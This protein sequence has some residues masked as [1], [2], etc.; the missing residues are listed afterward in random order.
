MADAVV[1]MQVPEIEGTGT[2]YG[3]DPGEDGSHEG[4]IPVASTSFNFEREEATAVDQDTDGE[5]EPAAPTTVVN[6]MRIERTA[7][8]TSTQL[9]MWLA[10]PADDDARKKEVVLIDY[11]LPSGKFFL[12]YELKGVELVSC[13]IN[14]Q[15]PDEVK[16]T[17]TLT[18]E[19]ITI[20]QRPV[21]LN[22]EVDVTK[23]T[24]STYT[25][26]TADSE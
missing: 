2:L 1:F 23:T 24:E 8:I 11:C 3:F 18:Y 5:A 6:P 21:D 12:R 25:V 15:E 17:L 16:E 10:A 26:I 20:F 7:D 19:E 14:Y 13:S 4:W 22:G 9:L